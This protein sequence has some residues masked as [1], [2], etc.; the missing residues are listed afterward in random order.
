M[1]GTVLQQASWDE[2][3][4]TLTFVAEAAADTDLAPFVHEAAFF[5]PDGYT[6]AES[7][8][9]G[10]DLETWEVLDEGDVIR[11]RYAPEQTGTLTAA[12]TF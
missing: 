6:F 4:A 3:S 2:A 1:G 9:S 5:V 11:I 8:P 7:T 10:V 12:L